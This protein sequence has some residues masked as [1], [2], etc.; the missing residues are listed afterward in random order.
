VQLKMLAMTTARRQDRWVRVQLGVVLAAACVVAA[1]A[2]CSTPCT[3]RSGVCQQRGDVPDRTAS[4]DD[5]VCIEEPQTGSHIVETRC[6][7]RQALDERREA[8][9][10]ILEKAMIRANQ[11]RRVKRDQ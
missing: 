7:R 11:P 3:A 4:G 2:G 6:Y 1:C 9:R 5:L 8:D 10:A